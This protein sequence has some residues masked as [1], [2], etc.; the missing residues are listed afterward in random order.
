MFINRIHV[1]ILHGEQYKHSVT[2]CLYLLFS[3]CGK[4]FSSLCSWIFVVRKVQKGE[5][6]HSLPARH[7]AAAAAPLVDT[8]RTACVL[9]SGS[10]GSNVVRRGR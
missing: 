8:T 9:E 10:I 1:V 2:A 5:V 4:M 3:Y 7:C 6:A